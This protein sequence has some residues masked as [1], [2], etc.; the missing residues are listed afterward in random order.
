MIHVSQYSP[1]AQ[2]AAPARY[3]HSSAQRRRRPAV[4]A[5]ASGTSATYATYQW[6][7]GAKLISSSAALSRHNSS[8]L[9]RRRM[10]SPGRRPCRADPLSSAAMSALTL[11][12]FRA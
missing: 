9:Q 4:T 5:R 12:G 8:T 11:A 7:N 6:L 10:S 1:I 2:K 3:A